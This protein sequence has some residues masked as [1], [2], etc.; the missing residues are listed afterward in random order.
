M[1]SDTEILKKKAA[2]R[3][4]L[5]VEDESEIRE[6]TVNFLEKFFKRVVSAQNGDEGLRCYQKERFDI[7]LTD[8]KMPV[9]D[10]DDMILWIKGN[11]PSQVVGLM[12]ASELVRSI[13]QKLEGRMDFILLKP[14]DYTT[15]VT[16]LIIACEQV[17]WHENQG[18]GTERISYSS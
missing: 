4:I 1:S 14:V 16:Q 5:Y 6:Q 9:M 17:E 11:R 12:S 8:I 7:V 3:A 10:G 18:A 15:L 13:S 2:S